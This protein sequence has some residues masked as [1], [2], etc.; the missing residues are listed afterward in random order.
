MSIIKYMKYKSLIP[1]PIYTVLRQLNL[2]YLSDRAGFGIRIF[3]DSPTEPRLLM[4]TLIVAKQYI[5]YTGSV[6]AGLIN[7]VLIQL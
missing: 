3:Q 1:N 5:G 4:L 6:A 2:A 7:G